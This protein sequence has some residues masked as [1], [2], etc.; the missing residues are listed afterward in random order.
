M[1]LTDPSFQVRESA[2]IGICDLSAKFWELFQANMLKFYLDFII[3]Q[4]SLDTSSMDVR[5]AVYKVVWWIR[6]H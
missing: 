1:L 3:G 5:A 2:V 4:L 6:G